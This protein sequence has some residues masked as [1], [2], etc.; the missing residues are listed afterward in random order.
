[1]NTVKWI[2][3]AVILAAFAAMALR[4][5]YLKAER[6]ELWAEV[7]RQ[8]ELVRN[9]EAK[10]KGLETAIARKETEIAAVSSQVG[11]IRDAMGA[12][13]AS[14]AAVEGIFAGASDA[15]PKNKEDVSD[16]NTSRKALRTLTICGALLSLQACATKPPQEIRV[17]EEIRISPC[18]KPYL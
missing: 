7:S 9:R 13:I 10:I 8:E 4:I 6:A 11:A 3:V 12:M 15:P 1:M 16:A 5:A 17:P 18:P 2:V 14:T